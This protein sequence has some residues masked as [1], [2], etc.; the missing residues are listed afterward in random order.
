MCLYA[1]VHI[2]IHTDYIDY[3]YICNINILDLIF[4]YMYMFLCVCACFLR[5]Y[6]FSPSVRNGDIIFFS[7]GAGTVI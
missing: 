6:V 1:C 3:M 4:T 7:Y 5:K 2:Y